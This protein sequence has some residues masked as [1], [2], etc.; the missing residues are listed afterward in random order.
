MATQALPGL[1]I[2]HIRSVSQ[3]TLARGLE[4]GHVLVSL[5]NRLHP[6]TS[7]SGGDR[8]TGQTGTGKHR[9]SAGGYQPAGLV[10][11]PEPPLLPVPTGASAVFFSALSSGFGFCFEEKSLKDIEIFF[12][13]FRRQFTGIKYMGTA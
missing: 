13:N 10:S 4:E 3:R 8:T 7:L 6:Q 11:L 9:A 2:S 12:R 1:A 5:Q